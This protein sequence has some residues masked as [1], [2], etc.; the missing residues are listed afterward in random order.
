MRL[1][2]NHSK[3]LNSDTKKFH[4]SQFLHQV[5]D[6]RKVTTEYKKRTESAFN[7]IAYV[8]NLSSPVRSPFDL[9]VNKIFHGS[10]QK[11]FIKLASNHNV[12]FDFLHILQQNVHWSQMF[13]TVIIVFY[14]LT[15]SYYIMT[16]CKDVRSSII[17]ACL[18]RHFINGVVSSHIKYSFILL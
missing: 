13:I 2:R 11:C 7:K 10:I 9:Y 6:F 14:I 18:A 5:M 12:H 8:S 15:V 3:T 16:G 1:F 17:T 4:L